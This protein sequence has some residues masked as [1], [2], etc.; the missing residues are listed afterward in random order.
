M[1]RGLHSPWCGPVRGWAMRGAKHLPAAM[2]EK[3]QRSPPLPITLCAKQLHSGIVGDECCAF[4]NGLCGEHAVEW[5]A[6]L[7]VEPICLERMLVGDGEVAE[8]VGD[9][10]CIEFA[11]RALGA[12][13][14]ANTMFGRDFPSAC[15]TDE[16][17]IGFIGNGCRSAS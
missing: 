3:A 9:D 14:L 16:H 4:D 12:W 8:A 13:Q 1:Q 6:M 17:G 11:E 5:V 7:D 10:K 15:G 2:A